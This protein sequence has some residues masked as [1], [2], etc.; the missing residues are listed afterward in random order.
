MVGGERA[1]CLDQ[2]RL[3][4]GAGAI[5]LYE[6]G[7]SS[8]FLVTWDFQLFIWDEDCFMPLVRLT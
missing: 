1:T 4:E 8:L 7:G 2:I 3:F 6:D 5:N